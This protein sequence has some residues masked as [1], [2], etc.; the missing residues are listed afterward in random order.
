MLMVTVDIYTLKDIEAVETEGVR[1]DGVLL[2]V[3]HVWRCMA[4]LN[5]PDCLH[6]QSGVSEHCDSS[7]GALPHFSRVCSS[8]RLQQCRRLWSFFIFG[9]TR[10][11]SAISRL[12]KARLE[13]VQRLPVA[14]FIFVRRCRGRCELKCRCQQSN[15][16]RSSFQETT[17][18]SFVALLVTMA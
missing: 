16:V 12:V 7:H 18:T 3:V 4:G 1:M 14:A 10:Q 9:L 13:V 17:K 11:F 5:Y 6:E 2:G 8:S 15:L